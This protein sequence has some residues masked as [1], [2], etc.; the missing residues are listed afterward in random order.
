LK[1]THNPVLCAVIYMILVFFVPAFFGRNKLILSAKIKNTKIQKTNL[2][3]LQ[4]ER[5]RRRD[6]KREGGRDIYIYIYIYRERER[7]R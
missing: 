6:T 7:E 2:T 1:I 5:E 3:L 4:R